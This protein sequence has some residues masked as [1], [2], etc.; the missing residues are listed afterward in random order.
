LCDDGSFEFYNLPLGE[1]ITLKVIDHCDQVVYEK[2]L[3]A[4]PATTFI[5]PIVIQTI[6]NSSALVVSGNAN[7]C[8]LMPVQN[9]L[10]VL[11]LD[12]RTYYQNINADGTFEFLVS[13]CE[14]FNGYLYIMNRENFTKSNT[15][16]IS[17]FDTDFDYKD[18]FVC[19]ELD[20]YFYYKL[21]GYREDLILRE[22]LF[23]MSFL[24]DL[25][26]PNS[27]LEII[28]TAT[29]F[30]P[31]NPSL[32]ID[33][34]PD[35]IIENQIMRSDSTFRIRGKYEDDGDIK[36]ISGT[37]ENI[38]LLFTSFS[39]GSGLE[40]QY[41]TGQLNGFFIDDDEG[42]IDVTASFKFMQHLE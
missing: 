19:D 11:K 24:P 38:E 5:L 31:N 2:I 6:A 36:Q 7:D 40:N 33:I 16:D 42:R 26:F 41:A 39:F 4:P 1:V 37:M 32:A 34:H 8:N 13:A 14:G 35:S 9:G 22:F 20:E 3:G 15:I 18:V 29:D 10:A 17:S 28:A 12:G 25:V 30:N 21:D 23:S 27:R